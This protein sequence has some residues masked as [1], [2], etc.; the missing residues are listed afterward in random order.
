MCVGDRGNGQG[1]HHLLDLGWRGPPLIDV[2]WGRGL[3]R[4]RVDSMS[5]A[6]LCLV[7]SGKWLG[8]TL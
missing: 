2:H 4:C 6:L 3:G 1:A 5:N 8:R 7:C